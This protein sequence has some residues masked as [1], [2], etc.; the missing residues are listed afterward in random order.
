MKIQIICLLFL[1]SVSVVAQKTTIDFNGIETNTNWSVH[2]RQVNIQSAEQGKTDAVSFDARK[3]DGLATYQNMEFE[4]GIIEVDIK[5]KNVLQK[6][7]VGIAF[8]IQ[9]DSTYNAIYFRPFNFT[10]PERSG[11]SVQYISH[12]EF[13]WRKLRSQF[14]EQFENPVK[15]VP[16][17][18]D[19][20]HTKIV[21]K[22]PQV[23]VFV[24]NNDEPSLDVKMKSTFKKGKIGLWA[25][26]GSDGWYKN[27]TVTPE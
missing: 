26:F 24:E 22:W 23:K 25:G 11:H 19:W 17:P 4:N 14:P 20:F 13:T 9:N 21:V 6:S 8:H 7:F 3:Y 15:P 12:P 1:I 5:G 27:L 10:K 18:D 16:D 2:N